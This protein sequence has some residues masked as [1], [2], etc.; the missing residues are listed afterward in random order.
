MK[1]KAIALSLLSLLSLAPAC[2]EVAIDNPAENLLKVI[3]VYPALASAEAQPDVL[4][5]IVFSAEVEC[6]NGSTNANN[7]TILLRAGAAD[8]SPVE[9][10][11]NHPTVKDA[12]GQDQVTREAVLLQPTQNLTRGQQYWIVIAKTLTGKLDGEPTR[13]L[14]SEIQSWFQVEEN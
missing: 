9:I 7:T 12:Q 13:E 6:A 5:V 4:P 8:G 2:G 1:N 10:A 3:R 14:G 11:V